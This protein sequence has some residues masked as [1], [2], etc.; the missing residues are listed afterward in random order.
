MVIEEKIKS[1]HARA[2]LSIED[3]DL[4]Y[5]IAVKGFDEKLSVRDVEKLV[6]DFGKTK[7]EKKAKEKDK[8]LEVIYQE[9]EQKLKDKVAHKTEQIALFDI[10]GT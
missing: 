5:E 9:I 3:N 8:A 4:Q 1:G 6:K 7:K 2:L 10:D